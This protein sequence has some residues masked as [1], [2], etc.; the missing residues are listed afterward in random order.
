LYDDNRHNPGSTPTQ[1]WYQ[2][3]SGVVNTSPVVSSD[4]KTVYVATNNS[5]TNPTSGRLYT[6]TLDSQGYPSNV[7]S[8]TAAN[9]VTSPVL[10]SNG[11]V[12]VG[13][14]NYLY[15]FRPDGSIKFSYHLGDRALK[16]TIGPN[17]MIY[18]TAW[19]G[20]KF[21]SIYAIRPDGSLNPNW[22]NNPQTILFYNAPPVLTPDGSLVIIPTEAQRVY[23][24]KTSDGLPDPNWGL[25]GVLLG[26][27]SGSPKNAPAVGPGATSK[28]TV[29]IGASDKKVYALSGENGS[30]LLTSPVIA[31]EGFSST[32]L[33]SGGTVYVGSF[34]DHL[35]ALDTSNLSVKWSYYAA[36]NVQ[37]TP[38][39]DANGAVYFGSD[40][41]DPFT[42]N[43]NVNALYSDGTVKWRF[44]TGSGDVRGTP[45][46]MPDGTVYIGSF[47]FNLY[48]ICQFAIPKSLKDKSIT[49]VSGA[50]GGVPVTVDNADD[51]FKSSGSKGPWAVRMEVYRSTSP[52]TSSPVGY[53]SY[54][55]RTWVRQC[56]QADCNDV[57]GSL[58]DD[59]HLT[60]YPTLR[61]PQMEQTINLSPGSNGDNAKLERFLFGFTSQSGSGDNQ[62]AIIRNLKLSFVRST[63]P[64]ITCDP[65]WPASTTCP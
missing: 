29:Y 64:T 36:G 44:S 62:Q 21:G 39:V 57:I 40:L 16:P 48:A 52:N 61:P 60:Y 65:T 50:V 53:Y 13:A 46:V 59:T 1:D 18:V 54:L 4:G 3:L 41:R 49:Y 58:Y 45:A 47:N 33:V 32:P 11:N 23:A 14:G 9:G 7:N 56:Q 35:Y 24:L 42:D 20:V 15:A 22:S 27:G 17:G 51:W 28:G 63:D 31:S 38:V 26:S 6:I 12:Y 55:L 5:D 8:W 30:T 25:T 2:S 10:D 19:D 43:Q 37:S 34:D